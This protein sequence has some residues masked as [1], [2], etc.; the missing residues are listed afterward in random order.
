MVG[1]WV[2]KF[3]LAPKYAIVNNQLSKKCNT[4]IYI[5]N[6]LSFIGSYKFHV[7]FDFHRFIQTSHEFHP[8]VNMTHICMYSIS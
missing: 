4:Y 1:Q 8:M 2:L 5:A 7:K 3:N 6:I